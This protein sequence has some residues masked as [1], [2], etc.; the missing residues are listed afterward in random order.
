LGG[1]A[2]QR[3]DSGLFFV[4]A[5]AAEDKASDGEEFFQQLLA[6]ITSQK[7]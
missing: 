4:A 5:S 1:A 7:S 2:L 6:A 3:C